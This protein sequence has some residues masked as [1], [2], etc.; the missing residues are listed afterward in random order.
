MSTTCIVSASET[1]ISP[2]A[3]AIRPETP[4]SISSKMMVGSC[5]RRA[6]IALRASMT[7]ESSPPEAMRSTAWGVMARL[8]EKR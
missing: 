6:S 4:V 3:S 1:M 7:R 2:I 8:A 5:M